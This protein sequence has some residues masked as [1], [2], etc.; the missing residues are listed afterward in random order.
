MRKIS[1][2][3]LVLFATIVHGQNKTF[4]PR[5][6]IVGDYEHFSVD[7][8]GRVYL[9]KDDVI[10]Q[11]YKETGQP[12][13]ST[14]LKT[15]RPFSIE[16]SKSFRTLVFD[17]ERA[18]VNFFDNTLT[19]LN[20]QIDLFETGI[21]QPWLV[22]ESFSGNSF[23]VLD[24]GGMQLVKLNRELE[25]ITRID[26]LSNLFGYDVQPKQMLE[27]NDFLYI[28]IPNK[29]VAIF[30]IFGT[31]IKMYPTSAQSLGVFNNY[32]LLRTDNYV[33]AVSNQA[34]L[35]SDFNYLIPE[36]TTEFI[37]TKDKVYLLTN[38]G[39]VIGEFQKL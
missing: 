31:F 9:T 14:S 2:I 1:L 39:L 24:G 16:S 37:F 18:V 13:Y 38:I 20:G 15:L 28:L 12:A 30:D 11:Y 6:T 32:L 27:Y 29:G 17:Q 3:G 8:F 26:N 36:G 33:E 7:N 19:D 21:Q 35:F 23:W 22:C 5:D 25:I 10:K 4:I 34:F